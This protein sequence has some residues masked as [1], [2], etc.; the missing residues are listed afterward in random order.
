M[1]NLFKNDF[2]ITVKPLYFTD[3]KGTQLSVRFTEVSVLQRQEMYDFWLFWDQM[4]C[5]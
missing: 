3:T 2:K 1:E 5:P 4:N